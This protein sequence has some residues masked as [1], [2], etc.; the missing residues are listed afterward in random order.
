MGTLLT[1]LRDARLA[2]T[3]FPA[4][5]F[6][7]NEML[8]VRLVRPKPLPRPLEHITFRWVGAQDEA[9]LQSVRPR[10]AGY[11][12]EFA[13]GAWCLLGEV[14][15]E[16]AACAFFEP[17]PVHV[18]R[19]NGYEFRFGERAAW[20]YGI[21]VNPRFRLTGIF[22]KF[23]IEALRLLAERG[24]EVVYGSVQ[25]DNPHSVNSHKRL[26]FEILYRFRVVRVAGIV[27]HAVEPVDRPELPRARGFG[28]WCGSPV[29]AGPG[30]GSPV[31]G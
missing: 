5:L 8:V 6:R 7:A 2:R 13:R 27:T 9:L 12:R 20:V 18:S 3:L 29:P 31:H 14:S 28:R 25:A 1:R 21:E 23:W 19:A 26:W 24:R 17:G 22:H 16:P 30:Q 11:G 4:W 15:G 10:R